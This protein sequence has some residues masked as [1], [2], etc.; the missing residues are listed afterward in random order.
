MKVLATIEPGLL[1]EDED[2]SCNSLLHFEE[3]YAAEKY[4]QHETL[5]P[6][7]EII[8]HSSPITVDHIKSDT[9]LKSITILITDAL[10]S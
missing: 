9:D 3:Q 4:V 5:S 1:A 2:S 6:L 7:N 8:E 10:D